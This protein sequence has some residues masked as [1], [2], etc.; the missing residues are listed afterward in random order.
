[1]P[2]LLTLLDGVRWD[3]TPVTGDRPQALLAA[4]ADAGRTLGTDR[5]VDLVWGEDEPANPGKALQVLVS[6][7]RSTVG[8]SALVTDGDGYRLA[9]PA[10]R[11]D[12][13][14]LR[15][16][17]R[18]ARE[19]LADD[20]AVALR[21]AETALALA[22]AGVPDPAA[23]PLAEV[24]R[25]ADH[26]LRD[27]AVVRARALARSG[28]HG[29]ALPGLEQAA[30]EAPDDEPLLVDLLRAEA[31]VRGAAVALERFEAHRTE[32]R[33]RL[34]SDPGPDLQRVHREL[35]AMDSPVRE[36]LRYAAGPLLGRDADLRTVEG[37]LTAARVVSVVGPGGLGKTTL[38]H[39]VAGAATQPVVHFVELV[40]VTAPEDLVG[41]VGSALGVRDSVSGRRTLTPEQRADVRA[42][43]AQQ[44]DQAPTLLVLDN[45]EHVVEAVAD[46]VAFLVATTRELRVLTTTR[47]PLA[48]AAERVHLLPHLGTEDAVDLFRTRAEAARPGVRLDE[49]AVRDVVRRLDGL[50]LAIEL[51]AAKVR[52]MAPAEIAR[53]LDDRFALLRGG[54]RSAPDRHRTLLAVIDWSWNLLAERERRALRYL[55]AFH[56]GFTLEAAGA[57]LGDDALET[58]EDLVE[59]S[60]LAVTDTDHGTRFRMLETVREFGRLQRETAGESDKV[61]RALQ[62]WAVDLALREGRRLFSTD[63]IEAMDHLREEETNLADVLREALTA[64][65][66][67]AVAT[68]FGT[69]GGY[70]SISGD[71][72]RSMTVAPAV[73]TALE[74]W[75]VP[76]ALV[77]TARSALCITLF[78]V[79]FTG[80]AGA[81][82]LTGQLEA[83]GA[84]TDHPALAALVRVTLAQ[85]DGIATDLTHLLDDPDPWV[86]CL[87]LQWAAHQWENNGDPYGAVDALH[88]ALPLVRSDE[89]PWRRA[90]IDAQLAELHAQLGDAARAAEHA[91][92]ALPVLERLGAVD[93]AVQNRA[94]VATATMIGGDLTTAA[95]QVAELAALAPTGMPGGDVAILRTRAELALITGEVAEGLRLH[96]VA[97]EATRAM[98]MPGSEDVTTPWA[99]SGEAAA[100]SAYALHG[101]GDEGR[102]LRD[103]LSARALDALDPER[104]FMDYPVGGLV[105]FG[106]GLWAL[107][108]SDGPAADAVRVLV[109]AERFSYYRFAPTMQ[110]ETARAL[111]DE[112]APGV[113]EAVQAEYGERRGPDLVVEARAAVTRVL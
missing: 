39:T 52:V 60:L 78:S 34:G 16:S 69:L 41:E 87:A 53:R 46:L 86:R 70:W 18:A 67:D 106:L 98:R 54:D 89:G 76:P 75:D 66:Q 51:A 100:V 29:E 25:R 77:D 105:L 33:D 47:A 107:V 22:P 112:R 110:W 111:C 68:L 12:A 14:Q 59:Q 27:A 3:G 63:Q 36:G 45:C 81:E 9:V 21:H 71:H 49:D 61:A 56:D 50:P 57:L 93:D 92:L 24:R 23:G 84:G 74:G 64:G 104:P 90:M 19:T 1:M 37:L 40:G 31:A 48:I 17:A 10:E 80:S 13:L 113:L 35:L 85:T 11:V 5:L 108:R 28:R 94:I 79:R 15:R 102:D 38:A 44:L 20:P 55:A 30:L 26:D 6:R 96:R 73:A 4:L 58:V 91:L 99:I 72:F 88:R 62:E 43:I 109:L 32:L 83:L 8:A 42:R 2:I 95:A 65:E 101:H 82:Q 7:V 97:A 103:A